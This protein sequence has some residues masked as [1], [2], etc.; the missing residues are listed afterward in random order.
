MSQLDNYL[1]SVKK[2]EDINFLTTSPLQVVSL[3]TALIPFLEHDDANRALMG[4]NMQRQAVPLL[5][6]QKPI[7]GTGFESIAI[8]DSGMIIKSY[9]QGKV[10]H[11]CSKLI[12]IKDLS[13]QNISYYLRKYYRSNQETSLN[14]RPIVWN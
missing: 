7:I 3:A 14:Q 5:Y 10:I 6:T 4:S 1:F 9:C 11:S 8:L 2:V 12:I 13:N